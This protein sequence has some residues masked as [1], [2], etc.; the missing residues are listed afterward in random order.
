MNPAR[1]R[2]ADGALEAPE[3]AEHAAQANCLLW[4][5]DAAAEREALA[6][7]GQSIGK[8][9]AVAGAGGLAEVM[10]TVQRHRPGL[11]IT[12]L[13]DG[14]AGHAWLTEL[15]ACAPQAPVLIYSRAHDDASAAAAL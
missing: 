6:A 13:P 10:A 7:L 15:H 2:N 11:I 14:A 3:A 8:P 5:L 9:A 1:E 4:R 12:D